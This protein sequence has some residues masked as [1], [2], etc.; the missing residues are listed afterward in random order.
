MRKSVSLSV[1]LVFSLLFLTGCDFLGTIFQT[2][3]GVGIAI[4]VAII[5][6]IFLIVRAVKKS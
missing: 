4:G 2:G 6:I 1:L 5:V 3:V